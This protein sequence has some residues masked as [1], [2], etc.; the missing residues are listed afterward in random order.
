MRNI[1]VLDLE[2]L[3]SAKDVEGGW[4]NKAELGLSIG[5][6]YNYQAETIAWFDLYSLTNLIKWIVRHKPLMVSFNGIGFDFALMRAVVRHHIEIAM[7]PELQEFKTLAATSYDILAEIWRA[8]PKDKFAKGLNSLDA[9]CA[10]NGLG[11]K[12]GS[13]EQ[14]PRDWQAGKKAKVMAYCAQD[15]ALTV[16]LFELI[17]ANKG[18]IERSNG[19]LQ[20]QRWVDEHG[21]IVNHDGRI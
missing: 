9:I 21:E 19:A 5:G 12:T 7:E 2:T 11:Q 15:I 6:Y 20:L 14:A 18:R 8:D 17:R 3:H 16:E 10:A 4:A 1:I 13:G